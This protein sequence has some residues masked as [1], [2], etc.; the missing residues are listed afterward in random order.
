MSES[1]STAGILRGRG[2]RVRRAGPCSRRT[3]SAPPRIVRAQPAADVER[4]AL[5]QREDLAPCGARSPGRRP[6]AARSASR[7]SAR[8]RAPAA[9]RVRRRGGSPAAASAASTTSSST[10][11]SSRS[12]ASVRSTLPPPRDGA[13]AAPAAARART[14]LRAKAGTALVASSRQASPRGAAVGGG[15]RARD[16]EQ[17]PHEPPVARAHAEQ[18]APTGRGGEPVEHGLDLVGRRVPGGDVAAAREL[19]PPRRSAASR[20]QAWRLPAPGRRGRRTSSGRRAARTARRSAPRRRPPRRAGRSC[21]GA[22]SPRPPR[23]S[24]PRGR[25][26]RRESRPPERSTSTGRPGASRPPRADAPRAGRLIA[27]SGA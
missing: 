19:A 9:A 3:R 11:A 20:A 16:A 8:R 10:S 25:A 2:R 15:L 27:G 17:R 23:R 7:C 22:P 21:S 26:G 1:R 5:A 24:A 18:R 14:R 13:R 12:S 4:A 6:R